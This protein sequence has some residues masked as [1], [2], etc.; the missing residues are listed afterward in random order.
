MRRITFALI[1]LGLMGVYGKTYA[2][3]TKDK[4][5]YTYIQESS[6][7][8][9]SY[10]SV[11]AEGVDLKDYKFVELKVKGVMCEDCI[12]KIEAK[13]KN[14]K[15]VV[16]MEYV[17]DKKTLKVFGKDLNL[18]RVISAIKKAGYRAEPITT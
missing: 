4:A 16:G 1:A 10:K 11:F 12:Q 2:C 17:W 8:P 5:S 6:D 13:L 7:M 18:D 3:P 9:A 15:G 14:V